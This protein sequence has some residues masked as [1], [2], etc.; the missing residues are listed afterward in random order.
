ME[1]KI[2]GF[3][4]IIM[5]DEHVDV[6]LNDGTKVRILPNGDVE[7]H[8]WITYSFNLFIKSLASASVI[9]PALFRANTVDPTT[10]TKLLNTTINSPPFDR[11]P[12]STDIK[13][14]QYVPILWSFSTVLFK[15]A[16]NWH[17]QDPETWAVNLTE[18]KI[19]IDKRNEKLA[20]YSM[21][22][23]L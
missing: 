13:Q 2:I 5:L 20:F 14:L 18:P 8:H 17:E 16:D 15:W 11:D 6:L 7:N 23:Y 3:K 4:D 1:N 10:L 19:D 22:W 21:E 12:D 9:A